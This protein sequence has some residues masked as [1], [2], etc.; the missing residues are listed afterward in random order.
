[1]NDNNFNNVRKYK[2][3]LHAG[4]LGHIHTKHR[5]LAIQPEIVYSLQ[6]TKLKL[7]PEQDVNLH[8]LNIPILIQYMFD[9][10]FRF[11]TGPQGGIL[12]SSKSKSSAG[13][14]T[15]NDEFKDFDFSWSFGLGYLGN[16]GFGVDGRYNLGISNTNDLPAP[17]NN[18][19]RNSV[20][21]LGVFYLFDH[22]HKAASSRR[23]K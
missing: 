10:G 1:V 16:S 8:Y 23:R 17:L 9:N 19:T 13:T 18:K 6:G 2:A 22:T 5:A 3:G 15:I 11:Q 12:L 7:S 4:V 14:F 20:F 21:Q